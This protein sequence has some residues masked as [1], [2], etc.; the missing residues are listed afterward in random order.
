VKHPLIVVL[1]VALVLG[2]GVVTACAEVVDMREKQ[3]ATGDGVTP[4]VVNNPTDLLAA[5][6]APLAMSSQR[7]CMTRLSH[8]TVFVE[9]PATR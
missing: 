4:G 5:K 9:R 1:A 6:V 3:P 2:A 7:S 8:S